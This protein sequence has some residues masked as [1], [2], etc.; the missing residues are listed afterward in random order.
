MS[1]S[2][3]ALADNWLIVFDN[4]QSGA[5]IKNVWPAGDFG[6]IIVTTQL[7]NLDDIV[8][9]AIPVLPMP[10]EEGGAL[11]R[12][13][14]Q[15]GGSEAE[16]AERISKELGGLPLAIAHFSGFVKR[17]QCSL[18]H[19]LES[20]RERKQSRQIWEQSD[21]TNTN[22]YSHTLETVWHLAFRRLSPD[23]RDLIYIMAFLEAD[24]I[25]EEMFIG[26]ESTHVTN[27]WPFWSA[28]RYV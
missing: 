28:H 19:V 5:S 12:A 1:H 4:V 2:D 13:Y 22:G 17:S 8:T 16:S 3:F 14:L 11:I 6:N 10:A 9:L 18:E 26:K 20:L 24:H 25:P 27:D 21:L 15:R 23:A 7:C